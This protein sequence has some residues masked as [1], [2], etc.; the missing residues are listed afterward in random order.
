MVSNPTGT[1][2]PARGLV[3]CPD[4]IGLRPLFV[5]MV[6]EL[7]ER[8]GWRV[9]AIEPYAGRESE[10]IDDRLRSP[11]PE[12]IVEDMCHAARLLA[13]PSVAA[14]GFCFGGMVAMQAAGTGCFTSIVS[15]Y[16]M[17]RVPRPWLNATSIDP[18]DAVAQPTAA[19]TLALF[20][21]QDPW[22]PAA[23]IAQLLEAGAET[24][25]YEHAEHAFAHDPDRGS[26]RKDDADDAWGRAIA[27]LGADGRH[28]EST[29]GSRRP[30]G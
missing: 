3:I 30:D 19:P 26:Y 5:D 9:C 10:P 11:M 15:F 1:G 12:G 16:G 17:P 8:L 20:G 18:V 6:A 24:V 7:A 22:T 4:L 27:F 29:L 2:A 21:G 23:D 28:P 13:T 14:M 25:V